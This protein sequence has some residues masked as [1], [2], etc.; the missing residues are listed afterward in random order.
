M[1]EICKNIYAVGAVD[2]DVRVFHGYQ[3]PVGTTYNAYLVVDERVTLIDTVKRCFA[4]V[5]LEKIQA[6]LGE[7]PIDCIICNHAEPDH[8][9]ALPLVAKAYPSAMVYGTASCQKALAAYYP[10]SQYP[11][12]PVKNGDNLKYIPA[13]VVALTISFAMQ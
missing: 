10:S 12:V 3:T 7:R 8:S 1:I 4:D 6:V 11:F 2:G 13:C 5:L 9:G